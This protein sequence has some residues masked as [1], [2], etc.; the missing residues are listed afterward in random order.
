MDKKKPNIIAIVTSRMGSTRFP[1][2]ALAEIRGM[3]MMGH[4]YHRAK[5][6]KLVNEVYI[7]AP[8]EVLH[9]YADS[10]GAK[11][12]KD[13]EESYRGCCNATSDAMLEI[14]SKYG[15][16]ADIVVM[17]QGDEPML[18]PEMI[19]MAIGPMLEDSSIGVVNLMTPI[20]TDEEHNDTNCPK[21]V[22]DKN[23]FALYF[24]REPIPSKRRV[25]DKNNST[26][27]QV[28]VMPFTREFLLKFIE[29]EPSPLEEIELIDMNRVLEH[30][31]K[32]KMVPENYKTQAIDTPADLEKVKE[33]MKDDPLVETYAT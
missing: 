7:T 26:F 12:V 24:S 18:V 33:M 1:G 6:S 13:R 25:K 23:N 27:K 8:D 10:I 11:W 30:G 4:V 17:I 14:E 9:D 2:K 20:E 15:D 28:C 19:D 5:M 32:V 3:S 21:V 31:Y 22:V 29:L 16:R